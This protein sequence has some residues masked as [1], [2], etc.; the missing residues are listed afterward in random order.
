MEKSKR[1]YRAGKDYVIGGVCAGLADY[2]AIDVTLLR[3][4]WLALTLFNGVGVIVYFVCM[5]LIPK[6]PQHEKLPAAERTRAGN[7]GLYVGVA[8]VILGAM[9]TFDNL[10]DFF[11]WRYDWWF[12]NFHW[13][14][15]WPVLLIL[16]GV[17][18]IYQ[19]SSKPED[20]DMAG[21]AGRRTFTRSKSQRMIGGVC[22]GLAEYWNI[23]VTLVR[24]GYVL[25]TLFTAV[26]VGVV[27]YVVM[28]F[29]VPEQIE[30]KAD[31]PRP[32]RKRTAAEKKSG[33]TEKGGS[34]E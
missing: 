23:D 31:A 17:W 10:F 30:K 2:L 18:F 26:W 25:A 8:L 3:I 34:H 19:A 32:R 27:A 15:V 29:I 33:Q 20:D 7:S 28:L 9:I 13:N 14:I 6:N 24:I 4:L 16:F 11:W 22:G 5:V 1:L 12:F 21:D